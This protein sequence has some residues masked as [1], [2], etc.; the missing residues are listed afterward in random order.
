MDISY[1]LLK[2]KFSYKSLKDF[3]IIINN[4]FPIPI[5]NKI[6]LDV[7]LKKIFNNGLIYVALD[8]KKI[9]GAC[10]FYCNNTTDGIAFLTLMGVLKEYR[11]NSIANNLLN[12]MIAYC[13]HNRFK[14]I[15]L[16]TRNTNIE[17]INLYKKNGFYEIESDRLNDLMLELKL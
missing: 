13:K 6:D 9:I 5:S 3:L 14:K 8:R 1:K 4:D 16:Y 2:H 17:A 7:F 11:K 12:L 10:F 15:R